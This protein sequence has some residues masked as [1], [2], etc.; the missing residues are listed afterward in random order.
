MLESACAWVH[1]CNQSGLSVTF[2]G[3]FTLTRRVLTRPASRFV[4]DIICFLA[5]LF[6]I[7]GVDVP[8]LIVTDGGK[9]GFSSVSSIRP[10]EFTITLLVVIKLAQLVKLML[11]LVNFS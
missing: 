7:T 1:V 6:Q 5:S 2:V 4:T 3:R 8:M 9:I 11:L 10:V